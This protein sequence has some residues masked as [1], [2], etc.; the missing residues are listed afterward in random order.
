MV[1]F[2]RYFG[3]NR[4]LREKLSVF[5]KKLTSIRQSFHE[6]SLVTLTLKNVENGQ[7]R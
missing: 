2:S 1:D 6:L 7:F 3:Q 4:V 5:K